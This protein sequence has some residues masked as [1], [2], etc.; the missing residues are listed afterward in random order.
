[1]QA[2]STKGL[3][4]HQDVEAGFRRGG[5]RHNVYLINFPTWSRTKINGWLTTLANLI[6]S[7]FQVKERVDTST[8][9]VESIIKQN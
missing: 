8:D 5:I 1:M 9:A 2:Q 4:L 7:N 6:L 3:G